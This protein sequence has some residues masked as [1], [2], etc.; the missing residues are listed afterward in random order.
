LGEDVW[1]AGD[2]AV[3]SRIVAAR[4]DAC[5]QVRRSVTLCGP[6]GHVTLCTSA[7]MPDWS[8]TY[9]M[10]EIELLHERM[11][12]HQQAIERQVEERERQRREPDHSE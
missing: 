1:K 2:G 5:G 8:I 7:C 9:H 10:H 11:T 6:G 4:C 12:Q 3:V